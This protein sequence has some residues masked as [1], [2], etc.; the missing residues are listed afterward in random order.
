MGSTQKKNTSDEK[1]MERR[2][3]HRDVCDI[4]SDC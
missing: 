3:A 4:R 2:A 1:E